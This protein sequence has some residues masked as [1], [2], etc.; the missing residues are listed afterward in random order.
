MS[1]LGYGLEVIQEDPAN[2]ARLLGLHEAAFAREKLARRPRHERLFQMAKRELQAE[3][4]EAA[5]VS[6]WDQGAAIS[7]LDVM[8]LMPDQPQISS[9]PHGVAR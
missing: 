5:F 2:A 7:P 4:G 6:A 9:D 3:L 1:A 8:S